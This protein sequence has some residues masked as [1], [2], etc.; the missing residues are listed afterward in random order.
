[1]ELDGATELSRFGSRSLQV[2]VGERLAVRFSEHGSVG[3]TAEV[4]VADPA[5]A[6]VVDRRVA[7]RHP[8][9]LKAGMTG[10]DAAVGAVFLEARAPGTTEVI[11]EERF[12]GRV[13]EATTWTLTVAAE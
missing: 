10:A 4:R 1:V 13:Q 6:A 11:L 8:E 5:V 12:R 3:E 9:K 2:T 7:H